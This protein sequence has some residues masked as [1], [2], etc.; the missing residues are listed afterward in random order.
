MEKEQNLSHG[1]TYP[2]IDRMRKT[3]MLLTVQNTYVT[4]A[5]GNGHALIFHR[6]VVN[7]NHLI[8]QTHRLLYRKNALNELLAHIVDRNDNTQLCHGIPLIL[9]P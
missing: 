6:S 8:R 9:R 1:G 2:H 3:A 4:P 5:H 7:N